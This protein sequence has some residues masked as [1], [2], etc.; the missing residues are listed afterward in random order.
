MMDLRSLDSHELATYF[1]SECEIGSGSFEAGFQ[2]IRR[3]VERARRSG[4]TDSEIRAAGDLFLAEMRSLPEK[5][6]PLAAEALKIAIEKAIEAQRDEP[7]YHP[8]LR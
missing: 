3:D 5:L 1:R 8:N 7:V 4:F 2:A 6:A